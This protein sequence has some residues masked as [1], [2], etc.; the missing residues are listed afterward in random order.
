MSDRPRSTRRGF[1][2]ALA[3]AAAAPALLPAAAV[4]G[5]TAAPAIPTATPVPKP[6]PP[7]SVAEALTEVV[8]IRW[9]KHLSGEQLGEIAKALDGRLKGAESMKKVSLPNADEPDVVFFAEGP[10]SR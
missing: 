8:R 5:Q 4:L 3:T 10:G 1:A 2:R 7:S 6:E 9:G